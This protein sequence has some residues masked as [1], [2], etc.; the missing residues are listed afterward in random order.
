MSAESKTPAT[1]DEVWAAIEAQGYEPKDITE[2]YYENDPESRFCLIKCISFE[3]EDI[4]FEFFEFDNKG[5]AV[6]IYGQA[7]YKIST[8]H[9]S[10]QKIEIDNAVAN[11]R[12]YTLDS[13]GQYGV[14]I[15]VGNT[16]VYARSNSENK[17]EI[18][19]ILAKIDYLRIGNNKETTTS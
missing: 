6:D 11:Y 2:I 13:L 18:N 12:I 3:H 9:N 15:Y 4:Y 16:A 17:Y 14:A 5:S 10:W 1:A 7:Y 19:K 8:S